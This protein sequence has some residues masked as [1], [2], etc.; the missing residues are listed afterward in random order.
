[1]KTVHLLLAQGFSDLEESLKSGIAF[2][3]HEI[4]DFGICIGLLDSIR[5]TP[6]RGFSGTRRLGSSALYVGGKNSL[7]CLWHR[8]SH[9]LRPQDPKSSGPLLRGC[10][11][12]PRSGDP[13]SGLPKVQEGEAREAGVACG[14][15]FLHQTICLLCGA[16]VSGLGDQ[17]CGQGAAP[18]LEDSQVPGEAIHAGATEASGNAWAEGHWS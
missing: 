2:P 17:G 8:S 3:W 6:L 1:M 18:R 16:A 13:T 15:S 14:Q 12:L 4:E 9:V 10:S 5:N 7:W 11:H